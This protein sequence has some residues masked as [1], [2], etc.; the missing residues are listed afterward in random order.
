MAMRGRLRLVR[1]REL[2]EEKGLE[3]TRDWAEEE[4]EEDVS[5]R[6]RPMAARLSPTWATPR[7]VPTRRT[8]T[9]VLEE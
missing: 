8:A 4:E 5:M 9:A 7:V 2:V 3:R 1:M 6:R